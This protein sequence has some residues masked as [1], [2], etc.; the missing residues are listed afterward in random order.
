MASRYQILKERTEP[1]KRPKSK[2][3]K[4]EVVN[5]RM[6]RAR[7]IEAKKFFKYAITEN[8]ITNIKVL[9]RDIVTRNGFELIKAEY[10]IVDPKGKWEQKY[11][12]RRQIESDE[13]LIDNE[14][15][16]I[17]PE[18]LKNLQNL[19][20]G[21]L[22][23]HLDTYYANEGKDNWVDCV[24]SALD[25]MKALDAAAVPGHECSDHKCPRGGDHEWGTDGVH[26]NEFC[27]KC[28]VSKNL[29]KSFQ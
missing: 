11:L 9:Q 2:K 5:S 8:K 14:F 10:G 21:A 6:V 7:E 17:Y 24:F 19:N 18:N 20:I 23:D 26:G 13:G 1:K 12:K 25:E 16:I 28:F 29:L 4:Q 22:K 27:K 3:K 15:E